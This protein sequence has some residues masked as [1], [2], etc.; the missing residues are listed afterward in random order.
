M[1]GTWED[2]SEILESIAGGFP[3]NSKEHRALTEVAWSYLYV[4]M[5]TEAK[6]AFTR[7][8]ADAN[9]DLTEAQ[10]QHL[11]EMGIDP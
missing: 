6:E 1:N 8:R 5:A 10:K 2:T 7:F 11:R 4:N 9:R 3:K